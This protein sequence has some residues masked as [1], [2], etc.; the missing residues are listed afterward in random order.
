M[1]NDLEYDGQFEYEDKIICYRY[2]NDKNNPKIIRRKEKWTRMMDFYIDG[3]H[4]WTLSFYDYADILS[5]TTSDYVKTN[6][7]K[8]KGYEHFKFI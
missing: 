5:N 6:F 8:H 1:K 4:F 3:R 7:I 2:Q